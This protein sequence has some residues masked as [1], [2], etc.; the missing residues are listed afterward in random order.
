[1]ENLSVFSERLKELMAE[2]ELRSETLSKEA[3]IAGSSIRSWL[4]GSSVPTFESAV[5]LADYF[6]CSLDY[7]AGMSE[8]FEAVTPR[9]L[10]PFYPRLRRIMK[11]QGVTRFAVTEKTRISDAFFT[12]WSRGQQPLLT[13]LCTLVSFLGVTLDYLVGRTDY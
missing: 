2:R 7:L 6:G 10:P 3:H 5:K 8:R 12:N 11:E 1:M 9:P 4:R 13:T